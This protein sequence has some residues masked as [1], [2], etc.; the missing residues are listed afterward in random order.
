MATAFEDVPVDLEQY[1]TDY[2]VPDQSVK[3]RLRK[4]FI[5]HYADQQPNWGFGGM[6][7][8]VYLTRYSRPVPD[9]DRNEF[10]FET[11]QRVVEGTFSLLKRHARKNGLPWNERKMNLK[12]QNM[13]RDIFEFLWT[14]PGRG[15]WAMGTS[16]TEEKGVY[17]SLF[18][19]AFVSTAEK[20][21]DNTLPYAYMMDAS[22]L[23]VGVGFDVHEGSR[24]I[25]GP[26]TFP[27]PETYDYVIPDTREGWVNSLRLL[28]H[29]YMK[30]TPMPSFD[31]S[32]IREKGKPIKGFGGVSSGPE[33]LKMLH[34]HVKDILSLRVGERLTERD[35]TDIMNRIGQCVIA[36]N[37]RRCLPE[38]TI[39]HTSEGLLPIE[40]VK[41]GM[42]A[43]TSEGFVEVTEM[44][45]QGKQEIVEI[46]SQLGTFKCTPDHRI[47]VL[48]AVGTYEWKQAQELR[49]GDRMVFVDEVSPGTDTEFP[50]WSYDK[51]LGSTTCTDITIPELDVDSAWFMGVFHGDGY[52][53][54]NFGADENNGHGGFNAHTSIACDS[55]HKTM[56]ER[57]KK[58]ME[59]FGVN[60]HMYGPRKD[61]HSIKVR[62]QSKQLTW[63]L[64]QFKEANTEIK[65]PEF[66]LR[67]RPEIRAGYLAGLFDADGSA[68]SRPTIAVSS[69]YKSFLEE[70]QAVY[71]S[72]GI[73]TRLRL[74][75]PAKGN[76]QALYRLQLVGEKAIS[77]F[78]E[79][80]ATYSD[81]YFNSSKTTRSQN[82]YSFPSEWMQ[83]TATKRVGASRSWSKNSKNKTVA[84]H[85]DIDDVTVKLV[86]VEVHEVRHTG[87]V[88]H[89]YDISVPDAKEFVAG[90]GLLVHNTAQIA[91]GSANSDEFL[92]LKN[93]EKNPERAPYGWASNNSVKASI[94]MDY[95]RVAERSR[96]NG[97]PGY[98]WL[99]NFRR[100]GRMG[101]VMPDYGVKGLN[102][103]GEI[104]LHDYELC[105]VPEIFLSNHNS[106]EQFGVSCEYATLY[107]KAVSLTRTHWEQA[108][109]AM[110]SNRRL[111]V[112]VTGV[113][114]FISDK[115]IERTA[116]F[117][118]YGYDVIQATDAE[119]SN[120][121]SVPRSIRTTS[122]KPSG[123]VSLLA[124][125]TPGMHFPESEFYIRRM[126][127]SKTDQ[128]L[129]MLM[130]ADYHIEPAETDP[131]NT[132][133]AEFY[134]SMEGVRSLNDVTMQEQVRLAE[135]MQRHW[136]DNSVSCTVT[137]DPDTEGKEIANV[138][139]YAQYNLKAISFLPKLE[140]GA[141]AQ[142][143]YEE[144]TKEDYEE[145]IAGINPDVLTSDKL[146]QREALGDKYCDSDG[147]II[148]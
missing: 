35:V 33:P 42:L 36:G 56:I 43:K 127:F 66:I 18:N 11:V 5:D 22:M 10:W 128:I 105:N 87:E 118:D 131:E 140:G 9:E 132:V 28:M 48:T 100:F 142:M 79:L 114:Q 78:E 112:S 13:Y 23:G 47:A 110:L 119:L 73:P 2:P 84:T 38:G 94:G 103:C 135:F 37:V 15:L 95:D 93:Y 17:M 85:E 144:I 25:L 82:D 59:R 52:V 16:L 32:E 26:V 106:K 88:V 136:A 30:R 41:P 70:V 108:N 12:A 113:T 104:G 145:K 57:V 55:T 102:P 20:R 54:P 146:Q 50:D 34:H 65:V 7:K 76:W 81:K 19:C 139:R 115:G 75:R 116:N 107:G 63:Y 1:H 111:G 24:R 99:D 44:V 121:F 61:D 60:I 6:G 90:P 68:T 31:Y 148:L 96:I 147:C 137:F 58:Q 71:A 80:V 117:L 123:T 69:V 21:G 129:P 130:E 45:D 83:D 109:Q 72:L 122:V 92:D 14:P 89:T 138:L 74:H 143:P 125:V 86:P 3:F 49:E 29:A 39:V 141:Y 53:Y 97:E 40:D 91:L 8:V 67:G 51:P 133:V 126:R 98:V 120:E 124:G 101:E 77:Q 62:A 134:V 27:E 4:K 46:D 64:A